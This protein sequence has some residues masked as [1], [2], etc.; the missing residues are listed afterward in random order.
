M[1]DWT[2]VIILVITGFILIIAEIL[3]VP[4]TTVVGI[5]GL[6]ATIF[7][8]YLSFEYFGSVVGWWFTFGSSIFFILALY[9]SFRSK[10]WDKLS[11]KGE[12]N[13]KVNEGLTDT[14][15]VGDQGVTISVL[16]P[17]GKAEIDE[18]VYEVRTTG[19]YVESGVKIKITKIDINNITVEPI[20]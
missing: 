13:S 16:R 3:F 12:I 11:L 20:N 5:L 9:Y 15:K 18:K 17:S 1:S 6:I 19:D 8:I 14:L 2:T 10:T 4:G 7:G